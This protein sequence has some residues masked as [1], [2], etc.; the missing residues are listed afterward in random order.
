[1]PIINAKEESY[2][3]ISLL[4][5]ITEEV[6]TNSRDIVQKLANGL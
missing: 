3:H 4:V 1:M 6:C 2:L 5:D